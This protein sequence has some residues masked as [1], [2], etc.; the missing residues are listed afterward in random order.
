MKI[1]IAGP[2]SGLPDFNCPAFAEAAA[3]LRSLGHTVVSPHELHEGSDAVSTSLPWPDLMRAALT[4][5]LTCDAIYLLRGWSD[6]RGAKI[7]WR[8]AHDLQFTV[9]YQSLQ[10]SSNEPESIPL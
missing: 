6:S 1:Y 8:L 5:M 10:E 9:L 2:M 4:E 7:E 3:H